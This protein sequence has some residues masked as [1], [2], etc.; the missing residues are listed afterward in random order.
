MANTL[1]T[2]DTHSHIVQCL[3]QNS[4]YTSTCLTMQSH[5]DNQES[6]VR[7][8]NLYATV[9]I[10][11]ALKKRWKCY[12]WTRGRTIYWPALWMPKR[13][14]LVSSLL[15]QLL[16]RLHSYIGWVLS[17]P[18]CSETP[19]WKSER[20]LY[21][22]KHNTLLMLANSMTKAFT[23]T[24]FKWAGQQLLTTKRAR[25]RKVLGM[26]KGRDE[27]GRDHLR[28]RTNTHLPRKKQIGGYCLW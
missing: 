18:R 10:S 11:E 20:D 28:R 1:G 13:D 3:Q 4:L 19:R 14:I 25:W 27:E 12:K 9:V 2:L 7:Q 26:K 15:L 17:T 16:F 22:L 8:Y 24:R 5:E 21:G 6:K 23:L